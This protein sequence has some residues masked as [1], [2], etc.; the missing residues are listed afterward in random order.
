[1]HRARD[2]SRPARPSRRAF[3]ALA[4]AA[5]AASAG[6]S[7]PPPDATPEGAVRLW[8]ERMEESADDR[9]AAR[10]A[11]ALLG[12]KARA[13][14]EERAARAS[15]VHGRQVEPYEMLAEGRFGL[16]FRPLTMSA[17]RSG[18]D[19]MVEVVGG[20]PGER[21]HVRCR[22]DGGGWR[23]EPSLPDLA[24]LVRREDGGT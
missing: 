4:L 15:R 18:D 23:V 9:R 7:R 19:A 16:R 2:V 13:N 5:V 11:F 21:A 1:M 14:L 22:L 20:A 10:E 6:C 3:A 24:P 8:L 17:S 12:P